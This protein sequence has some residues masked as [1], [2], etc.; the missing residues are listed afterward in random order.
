MEHR[1]HVP[2]RVLRAF[3]QKTAGCAESIG[4]S[5]VRRAA[6]L[7]ESLGRYPRETHWDDRE[8]LD[9]WIDEITELAS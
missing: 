4:E 7:L 3:A 5:P 6:Q 9:V 2:V 1:K 8:Y